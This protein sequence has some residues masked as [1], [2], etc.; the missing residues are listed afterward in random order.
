MRAAAKPGHR[1]VVCLVESRLV[2]KEQQA[3]R[4][5]ASMKARACETHQ[6]K[7]NDSVGQLGQYQSENLTV[8]RQ[9]E[10]TPR[11]RDARRTE[12][13]FRRVLET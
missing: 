10:H 2:N 12:T 9:P 5:Q 6:Q 13:R 11:V 4:D 1:I 7:G 3:T 8:N